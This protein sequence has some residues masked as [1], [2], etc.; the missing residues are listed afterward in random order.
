[1]KKLLYIT[2]GIKGAA[3][4]ERVLSIKASELAERFGYDVHILVLNNGDEKPFYH[5]SPKI[6]LHDII[7]KGN[8]VQYFSSYKN[9][10]KATVDKVKP[11]IISVCDDGLKGFFLPMILR[12][13]CPMVYERHVSKLIELGPNPTAAKQ[14]SVGLKLKL[15]TILGR[16]FDKFIV[17]TNDNKREWDL[18]NL[19]VISNPL[20]FYPEKSS[21]LT[22]KNVIA[23]GRQSFQKGYDLLLNAWKIVNVKDPDWT[24]SIYGKSDAEQRLP[25]LA[26]ALNIN[27]SVHFYEPVKDIDMKFLESSIF[28]FPSRFEGFGMV[29]IEAMACGVPCV[30]FDCPY[31]PADI[32][33][34][35]EDG[36]LI[37][38]GNV[39]AFAQMISVLIADENLRMAMGKRA[40]EN[41]IKF[42]AENIIRQWDGLFKSFTS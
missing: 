20:S 33:T 5:F 30:S 41:V 35:G 25:E 7:V 12:K 18:P 6:T 32:V 28:V 1:M 21:P 36:F 37:E 22:H 8:P 2:N 26:A 9:G 10:I 16:Q 17:L 27:E 34:D 42:Q 19:K 40:K 39:D 4:L 38:N 31:G 29:L 23:V 13:P 3:G 15:M 11:D 24:L 14:L